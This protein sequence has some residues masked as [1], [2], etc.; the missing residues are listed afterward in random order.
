MAIENNGSETKQALINAAT[1]LFAQHGFSA[2]RVQQITDAAGINKAMLYYYFNG[3]EDIYSEI[4]NQG[5]TALE[6]AV[7]AAERDATD[8]RSRLSSFLT[9][10]LSVV[11]NKP[12]LAR[13]IYRE[14]IGAGE[15]AGGTVAS[16]FTYN[17][18][19]IA[20]ILAASGDKGEIRPELDPT[21]AAYSLFGM[22][23][24][25]ITRLVVNRQV[26]DVPALVER[27]IDL[28]IQGACRNQES[29]MG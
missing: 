5:I 23:N 13:I 1:T 10:Y 28:F 3:K 16:H 27:I 29:K 9:T 17:V 19:R 8:I 14:A 18:Q 6:K 24:M 21:F 7:L 25:F 11:S 20:S 15:M 2:T 12:E 26:L 4:I 22:A